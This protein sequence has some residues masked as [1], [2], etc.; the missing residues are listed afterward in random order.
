MELRESTHARQEALFTF[1]RPVCFCKVTT[2]QMRP[3]TT[4]S[5]EQKRLPQSLLFLP[6][7]VRVEHKLLRTSSLFK[8]N[9]L[10]SSL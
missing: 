10:I 4:P 8:P 5:L 1:A 3:R 7:C 2:L 9:M 6:P